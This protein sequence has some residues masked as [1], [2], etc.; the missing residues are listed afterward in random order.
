M[1]S[2][3][4]V[5]RSAD[6]LAVARSPERI[7]RAA[8][9]GIDP[10][11]IVGDPS[12]I[13]FWLNVYNAI[14]VDHLIAHPVRGSML[15]RLRLFSSLRIG[16]GEEDYSPNQIEHG[17]LRGNAR[18]PHWPLRALRS[19]DPRAQAAPAEVDPRIH[20]ALNC[21]AQSCPIIRPYNAAGLDR[22]LELATV[23]YLRA[24]VRV[25][26]NRVVL[27]GVMRLYR[28][29]F[30]DREAQLRFAGE[31]VPELGA[32]ADGIGELRVGYEPF[33]WT[34]LPPIQTPAQG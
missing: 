9:R 28:A 27:P 14:L 19:G 20:F 30:G 1:A 15:R 11:A 26:G 7:D 21:G 29:D 18:P 23:A 5:E 4:P 12:R 24:E 3:T 33:D 6:L 31:R 10:A 22:G 34:A 2:V 17:L 13:A 8:L 25:D 32:R 16:V